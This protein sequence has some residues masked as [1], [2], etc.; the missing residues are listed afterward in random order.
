[1]GTVKAL[2]NPNQYVQVSDAGRALVFQP[3][4]D[5]VRLVFSDTQPS[6]GNSV[7]HMLQS[8]YDPLIVPLSSKPAWAWA[9]TETSSLIITDSDP[10]SNGAAPI[11][12][13]GPGFKVVG[14]ELRYD[15]INLPSA[16]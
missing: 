14:S 16:P 9:P 3:L 12:T 5:A 6:I 13:V 1:M 8:S 10:V 15:I 4:M 11:L 2:L 7:Y